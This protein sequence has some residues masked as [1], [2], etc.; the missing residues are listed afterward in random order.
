MSTLIAHPPPG[1]P[2]LGATAPTSTYS[3][4]LASGQAPQTHMRAVSQL[5]LPGAGYPSVDPCQMAP[6]PRMEAPIRQEHLVS[7]QKEPRTSYQQQIEAPALSTHSTGVRRGAIL[8]MMRR[9]SQELEHQAASVGHGQGLS[10]KGQGAIPKQ[11]EEAPGQDPQGLACGRSWSHLRKGFEQRQWSKLTPHP[12]GGAFASTSGAPSAP[13]VQ[14]GCFHPRHPADFRGEG[15]KKEAHQAYLFHISVTIN[16][17]A[18]EAEAL[19]T[20]VLRH[21]E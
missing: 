12:G 14:L 17:T 8:E 13:P 2:P 7:L 21:M 4:A 20:L 19:T 3:E 10:T 11:T 1:L 9:K 5:P 18:E 15:W 6:T 16:V